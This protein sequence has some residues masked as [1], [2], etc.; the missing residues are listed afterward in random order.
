MPP[1]VDFTKLVSCDH[2]AGEDA[3][4][5]ALVKEMIERGKS[6]LSSFEWCGEVVECHV[7]DIAVG[8]VVVVLLLRIV[9][10]QEDVDEWLWVI[11]G[12]LPPA[13]VVTD[14]SP[15]A[16]AALDRYIGEME[17][18][19]AA[20]KAGEPLDDVIPVETSGGAEPLE[21]TP[22]RADDVA[23]RLRFLDEEILRYHAEDLRQADD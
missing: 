3:E 16:A 8:G 17:R 22:E 1:L 7:G 13:Y 11:V 5:D 15:N 6:Y 23:R 10:T 20:V 19:V 14:D 21:P 9:P 18:W 2:F 4:D 12:D